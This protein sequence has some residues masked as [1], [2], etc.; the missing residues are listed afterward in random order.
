M[1]PAGPRR[2]SCHVGGTAGTRLEPLRDGA[3]K[4][5]DLSEY[6]GLRRVDAAAM[7]RLTAKMRE[8]M[9]AVRADILHR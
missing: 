1:T 5:M 4:P 2:P 7:K 6:E 3:G 8:D 9:L